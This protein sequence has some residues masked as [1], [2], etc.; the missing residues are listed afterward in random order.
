MRVLIVH[1]YLL[2]GGAETAIVNLWCYL[3]SRGVDNTLITLAAEEDYFKDSNLNIKVKA[4]SLNKN[5]IRK[6]ESTQ[7]ALSLILDALALRKLV[8]KCKNSCDVINPH[9]IPSAWA[10][11]KHNKPVAWMMNEAPNIYVNEAPSPMLKSVR[12]LAR[13]KLLNNK[14][15]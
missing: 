6:S 12:N 14:A 3:N 7:K 2:H 13:A 4:A 1:P 11:I 8:S 15:K 10:S 5:Q 9:N